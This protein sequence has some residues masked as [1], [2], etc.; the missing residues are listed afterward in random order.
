[1]SGRRRWVGL[2]AAFAAL[3][4]ALVVAATTSAS[5]TPA[6]ATFTLRAGDPT[7][8]VATETGKTATI[9][10]KPPSADRRDRD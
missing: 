9:P 5:L 1:V 4:T 10:A 3:S 6:S 8:G 2:F 7:L